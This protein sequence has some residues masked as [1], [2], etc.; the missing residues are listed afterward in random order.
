MTYKRV[1]AALLLVAYLPGCTTLLAPEF[2]TGTRS[3]RTSAIESADAASEQ[4]RASFD[5]AMNLMTA[6]LDTGLSDFERRMRNNPEFVR[7]SYR[8]SYSGGGSLDG[9]LILLLVGVA[10]V[11]ISW[12]PDSG[13]D[14]G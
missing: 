14:P 9:L 11:G 1:L 5:A 2:G 7:V 12:R 10:I 8:E 13:G 3:E 6:K 4:N